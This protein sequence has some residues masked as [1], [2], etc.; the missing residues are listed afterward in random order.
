[1]IDCWHNPF[2]H[3]SVLSK[4]KLDEIGLKWSVLNNVS[5]ENMYDELA[6]Y[7]KERRAEDPNNAWD[8]NCPTKHETQDGKALGRWVNRQR[9]LYTKQKLKKEYVAKLEVLGLKWSVHERPRTTTPSNVT[10]GEENNYVQ[11]DGGGG[12]TGDGEAENNHDDSN[13]VIAV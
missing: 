9:T 12:I 8:G 13:L 7:A 5:W 3:P 10:D 4:Q 6:A 11:D 1:L 2:P